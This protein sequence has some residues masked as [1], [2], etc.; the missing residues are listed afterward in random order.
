MFFFT[1]IILKCRDLNT[2]FS[3]FVS[4]LIWP[5]VASAVL[6]DSAHWRYSFMVRCIKTQMSS[7]F[8]TDFFLDCPL[9]ISTLHFTIFV[10]CI[11]R[12]SISLIFD[13]TYSLFL[14]FST[15]RY[16]YFSI[17]VLIFVFLHFSIFVFSLQNA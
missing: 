10:F 13:F 12:F 4:C 17:F 2:I 15:F 5:R 6:A 11:F 14:S 7:S 1:Y 9:H 8:F 16:F 3:F